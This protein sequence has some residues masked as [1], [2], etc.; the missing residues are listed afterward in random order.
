MTEPFAPKFYS[1]MQNNIGP[2]IAN[3]I[4]FNLIDMYGEGGYK[5]IAT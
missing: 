5:Y 1:V 3:W 2:N 4:I